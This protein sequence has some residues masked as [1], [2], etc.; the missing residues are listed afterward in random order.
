MKM[1]TNMGYLNA[2]DGCVVSLNDA[3][4]LPHDEV[5]IL[6]TGAQGEPTSALVR[7]ANGEHQDIEIVPGDTVVISA[8]P[9]PGNETVVAR[10]IDNLFRQQATVLHSRIATVH[11]HGHGSREELKMMLSLVKPKFFVPVHGEYRHLVAHAS[12]A[13]STG[14]PASDAFVLEDGD[15][16]ELTADAGEVV[17]VVKAGRV[18]ISG[19]RRWGMDSKLVNERKRLAR[20]GVVVLV[21]NVDKKTRDILKPIDVASYGFVELD[22][23]EDLFERTSEKA[24]TT[25]E[26][27]TKRGLEWELVK[28]GV[29]ES[30][31]SFPLRRD[32]EGALRYWRR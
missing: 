28:A 27:H 4:Q 2:P 18:Y 12:I 20:D 11:V 22:E 17:D 1:A 24:R 15:V 25:L 23:S 26:R 8:S 32:P 29:T 14:V 13:N 5:V 7:I 31:S 21:I 10:T 3:R 9:I 6:A 16:L 30:I 19:R